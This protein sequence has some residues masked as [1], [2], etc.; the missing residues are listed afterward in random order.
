MAKKLSLLI[1][2]DVHVSLTCMHMHVLGGR[3][4]HGS[5]ALPRPTF[6]PC[7]WRPARVLAPH[8]PLLLP[9]AD[10]KLESRGRRPEALYVPGA[11][12]GWNS[13]GDLVCI[14]DD[15]FGSAASRAVALLYV[16]DHLGLATGR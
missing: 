15:H 2:G 3:R 12:R 13:P 8:H 6:A 11:L 14:V 5:E 10:D 1:Y 16:D 4:R 9:G 7:Q